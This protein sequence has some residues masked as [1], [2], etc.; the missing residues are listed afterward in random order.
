MRLRLTPRDETALVVSQQSSHK[1]SC[2]LTQFLWR[3][4]ETATNGVLFGH[5]G[6]EDHE[7]VWPFDWPP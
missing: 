3:N 7:E 4:E 6:H 1:M 5:E 2:E